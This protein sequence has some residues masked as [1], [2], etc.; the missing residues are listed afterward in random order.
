MLGRSVTGH[1]PQSNPKRRMCDGC[2]GLRAR[3]PRRRG[4]A[5]FLHAPGVLL[6]R[7]AGGTAQRPDGSLYQPARHARPGLL[8]ARNPATWHQARS[9]LIP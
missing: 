5:A 6:A 7:E 3:G 1:P 4:S 8:V 9:A 2:D